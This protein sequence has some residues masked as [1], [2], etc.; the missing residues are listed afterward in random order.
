MKSNQAFTLRKKI[1]TYANS[2]VADSW[3]GSADPEDYE[4]ITEDFLK[5]KKDLEDYISSLI[6]KQL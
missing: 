4:V 5:A 6:S 2:M 3:R 1:E